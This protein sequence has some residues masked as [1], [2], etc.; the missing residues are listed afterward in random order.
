M[1]LIIRDVVVQDVNLAI[2][3]SISANL[4]AASL[5]HTLG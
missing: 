4:D 3:C 5:R 2:Q 1:G